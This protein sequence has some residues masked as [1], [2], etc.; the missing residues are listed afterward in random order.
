MFFSF[1]KSIYNKCLR[2]SIKDSESYYPPKNTASEAWY[3]A[4]LMRV[5]RIGVN[6]KNW[7]QKIGTSINYITYVTNPL[8]LIYRSVGLIS[9]PSHLW[10]DGAILA[11]YTFMLLGPRRSVQKSNFILSPNPNNLEK[12]R[13]EKREKNGLDLLNIKCVFKI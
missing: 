1:F 9:G 7:M 2:I 3:G 10:N 13:K 4:L 11:V 5:D 6:K 8:Q 12:K